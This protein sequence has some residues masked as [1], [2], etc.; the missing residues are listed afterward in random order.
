MHETLGDVSE[1]GRARYGDPCRDCGYDWSIDSDG[2]AEVVAVAPARYADLL[3]GRDG[4]QR[5]PD[6]SWSAGTY[7]CHVGDNL[8]IWAERLAALAS[9]ATGPVAPYDEN[10]LARARAYH[11]IPIQGA[12]WSL[13]RA[14]A[15]WTQAVAM[16]HERMV[17]LDHP[18]RGEQDV[19]EV[20]RMNAHDTYHHQWDIE[21]SIG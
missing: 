21:R 14:A 1:W 11:A 19:L 13:G 17:V 8:R 2:A 7:V 10:A 6:L 9:G 12:L 15:D 3:A 5:H 4:S 18:E 20:T 16:A